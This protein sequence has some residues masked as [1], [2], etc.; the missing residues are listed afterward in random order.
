MTDD[1]EQRLRDA[2]RPVEPRPEFTARLLADIAASRPA[3]ASRKP[4][5]R[6]G[7]QPLAAA[8]SLTLCIG[9][10]WQAFEYQQHRR[11]AQAHRQLLEALAITSR[12]LDHAVRVVHTFDAEQEHGG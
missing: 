9:L 4:R 11:A 12:S 10:G 8:A 6:V 5:A 1:L 3:D 7:W 2:L